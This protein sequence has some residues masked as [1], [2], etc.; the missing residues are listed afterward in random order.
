MVKAIEVRK[1]RADKKS[2][3]LIEPLCSQD[4]LEEGKINEE[5]QTQVAEGFI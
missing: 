5:N 2:F 3:V 1:L 4:G